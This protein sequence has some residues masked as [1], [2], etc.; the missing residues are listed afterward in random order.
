MKFQTFINIYDKLNA[1]IFANVLERPRFRFTRNNCHAQYVSDGHEF[2]EI[3]IN[4]KDI[5]GFKHATAIIYH[6]M[7]H[8]YVEEFLNLTEE[9]HHGPIFWRNYRM[10]APSGVELGESL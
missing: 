1:N 6:E 10:F 2:S 5:R 4:P 3:H 9:N 8:Q 7:I